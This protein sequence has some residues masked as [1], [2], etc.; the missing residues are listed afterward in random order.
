M[1]VL[2]SA[3]GEL[4][5][6]AFEPQTQNRFVVVMD[7]IASYMIKSFKAP[8]YTSEIN[9]LDHI[10]KKRKLKGKS[11]WAD[12]TMNLYNPIVPSGAQAVMEWVRLHHESVTGRDGYADFYKKDLTV[13]GL[14]PVGDIITEWVIKGA[15]VSNADF[16]QY[17][18]SV[19][20]P[21]EINITMA[22]DYAIHNF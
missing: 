14:G 17:D 5:F 2:S 1:A 16:G 3:A 12:I 10:N 4:F 13:Q 21:I 20:A 8:T 11:D 22:I 9:V 6:Q 7:G 18:W 15:V 19:G